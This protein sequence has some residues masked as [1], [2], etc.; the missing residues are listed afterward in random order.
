VL[1][2]KFSFFGGQSDFDDLEHLVH[3]FFVTVHNGSGKLDDGVH[4][5]LDESS[6]E[7]LAGGRETFLVPLL[8]FSIEVVVTPKL[9][10]QLIGRD[11]ELLGVHEGESGKGE[12]PAFFTRTEG[13]GTL[14]GIAQKIT[15]IGLFVVGDNDVGKI[16]DSDEVLVHGFT[17]LLE[18]QDRSI[19]LVNHD[20]GSDLF[21]HSLS[22]DSF[23]LDANTF[24]AIDDDESTIGN[25]EGS[26]DFRREIDMAGRIDKVDKVRVLITSS[27]E[28]VLVEQ[29]DTSRLNGDTSF[30][31]IFSGIGE[32]SFTSLGSSDNTS[33]GDEGIGK[34]GLAVI[35][36]GNNR[37]V[38]DIG[39]L[40]H[41]GSHLINS[42]INHG[43]YFGLFAK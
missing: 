18:F 23:G 9:F 6:L 15:H 39:G 27:V 22:H 37:N 36:V 21:T 43:D 20:N 1:T 5:E 8:G 19:D 34:G 26:S 25:S 2:L 42:E 28:I 10:H 4:D 16:N 40:V 17:I 32:T 14:R 24:D 35:D 11:T 31:F 38:S 41:N 33:L 29:G 7:G 12:A 13:D 3:L 30:L